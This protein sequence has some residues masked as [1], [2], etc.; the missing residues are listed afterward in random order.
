MEWENFDV[1]LSWKNSAVDTTRM[2]EGVPRNS[3]TEATAKYT[4]P[5]KRMWKLPTSTQLR[6]TW[7][8]DSLDMVVLPSTGASCYHNGCI[9]GGTSP[10]YFGCTLVVCVTSCVQSWS[11]DRA[12][13]EPQDAAAILQRASKLF[14]FPD[15]TQLECQRLINYVA[16]RARRKDLEPG[17]RVKHCK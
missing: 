14:R 2:H 3:R 1:I 4:T 12:I 7:H 8:T 6:A 5:N 9:D 11:R 10:E 17:D 16:L 13:S 15:V